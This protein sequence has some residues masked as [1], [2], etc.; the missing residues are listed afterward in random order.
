MLYC[1]GN[2]QGREFFCLLCHFVLLGPWHFFFPHDSRL[3]MVD[4]I[5]TSGSNAHLC[6][7]NVHTKQSSI[8]PTA[9][10]EFPTH[11]FDAMLGL[12]RAKSNLN[13]LTSVANLDQI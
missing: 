3:W 12:V 5:Q 6:L 7:D 1:E 10:A 8:A 13:S 4:A 11:T 9:S 2:E